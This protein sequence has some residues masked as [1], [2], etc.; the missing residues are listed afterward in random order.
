MKEC[1]YG[2]I[3]KQLSR[4]KWAKLGETITLG[5]KRF[6]RIDQ[7]KN[8]NR[9]FKKLRMIK[10]ELLKLYKTVYRNSYECTS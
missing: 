2:V 10:M 8:E 3:G 6:K 5:K 9:T 4:E 7:I 1:I